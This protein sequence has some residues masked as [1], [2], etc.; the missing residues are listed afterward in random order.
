MRVVFD[1]SVLVAAVRSR[2][3]ASF[4]LV[5]SI[6]SA[7]FEICLSIGLYSEWQDVLTR[8]EHRPPGQTAAD[9]I[10]FTRFLAGQAWHQDVFFL[11]RP[12]LNDPDDDMIIELALAARSPYIVTHNLRDFTGCEQLGI[13]AITPGDF[14]KL[15]TGQTKP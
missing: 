5:N 15:V 14:L 8:P 3:G 11:W 2:G 4:A 1:S 12:F 13:E 9:M 7:K 6:P 10:A